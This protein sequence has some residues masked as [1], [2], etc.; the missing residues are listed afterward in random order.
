MRMPGAWSRRRWM[1]SV[2]AGVGVGLGPWGGCSAVQAEEARLLAD[3]QSPYNHIV[4]A[5]QGTVRTMYFVVDGTYYI[6]SRI[7][8]GHP[9]SLDLDYTLLG[10][11]SLPFGHSRG[12]TVRVEA[13]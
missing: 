6:E 5:E 2:G 10:S 12:M 4:V 13:P 7:D 11:Y 3:V 9:R 8:R 1:V